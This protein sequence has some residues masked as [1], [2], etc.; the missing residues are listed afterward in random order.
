[1]YPYTSG[2]RTGNPLINELNIRQGSS[3]RSKKWDTDNDYDYTVVRTVDRLRK[4]AVME[5]GK[6]FTVKVDHENRVVEGYTNTYGKLLIEWA[7][8]SEDFSDVKFVQQENAIKLAQAYVMNYFG[9]LW[10]M[11]NANLPNELDPSELLSQASDFKDEI[12]TKWNAHAKPVVV[13]G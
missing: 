11:D 12:I 1:M 2:I 8:K 6:T 13:R 4:N 10:S 3:F 7:K 5:K 9:R